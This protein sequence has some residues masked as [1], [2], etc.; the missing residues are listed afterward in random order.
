MSISAKQRFVLV[1]SALL[2]H[3]FSLSGRADENGLSTIKSPADFFKSFV[4]S[5]PGILKIVY[6]QKM[7]PI[8]GTLTAAGVVFTH[9]DPSQTFLGRYQGRNLFLLQLPGDDDPATLYGGGF[10]I[11]RLGADYWAFA[12]GNRIDYWRA[13]SDDGHG[14]QCP[15]SEQLYF[16][17]DSLRRTLLFGVEHVDFGQIEWHGNSF[18]TS[19]ALEHCTARGELIS[20]KEGRAVRLDVDYGFTNKHIRST[21]RYYYQRNLAFDYLPSTTRCFWLLS[22]N[23][24]VEYANTEILELHTSEELLASN[25]FDPL[26]YI[27]SNH[28][29]TS[30]LTN[31]MRFA[32]TPDGALRPM[33]TWS[34]SLRRQRRSRNQHYMQ[35]ASYVGFVGANLSFLIL[36]VRTRDTKTK[37]HAKL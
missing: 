8:A 9:F 7:R 37:H 14:V 17:S 12:G 11:S 13:P 15:L 36:A 23:Q 18:N 25:L 3:F 19:N 35:V 20:D 26:Q 31:G 34:D 10:L 6:R 28:W 5:P 29:W 30:I 21:V 27:K 24:V 16:G 22:N 1:S 32:L 2:I 4:E 33:E